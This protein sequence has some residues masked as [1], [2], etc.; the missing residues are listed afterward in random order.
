M[1]ENLS[2]R[3]ATDTTSSE[4][5]PEFYT[6]DEVRIQLKLSLP[7]VY[8]IAREDPK[9]LGAERFGRAVRFRRL[10]VDRLVRGGS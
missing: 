3:T 8:E 9:R 7:T 1:E 2:M 5:R 4:V 10:V 6:A